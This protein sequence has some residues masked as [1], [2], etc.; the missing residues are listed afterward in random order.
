VRR[1]RSLP[2]CLIAISRIA[3]AQTIEKPRDPR[4]VM[5]ERPTVA[6][7]AYTVAP[8]YIEIEAGVESDR[9][10]DGSR[11]FLFGTNTKIG[12]A[13][14]LQLGILVPFQG[15]NPGHVGAGDVTLDVKWRILDN[16]PVLGN[17]ALLPAVKL[18]TGPTALGRGTGTTDGMITLISSRT[19]GPVSMDLNIGYTRRSGDGS[20]APRDAM[21]WTASFGGSLYRRV[22]WAFECY[23]YPATSGP[24]GQGAYSALLFGPTFS[25]SRMLVFDT[26]AIV[27]LAGDQ[28]YGLYAGV[29]WNAGRIAH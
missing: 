23:G 3:A 6:T 16:D 14:H 21:L 19:I 5:P 26:G 29:V 7:H 1:F 9:F 10:D 20:A 15:G 4:E 18:A 24:A 11:T 25:P 13:G 22:G 12:L 28:S 27:P 2:F 17:F 8:G